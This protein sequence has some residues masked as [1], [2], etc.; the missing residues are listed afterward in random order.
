MIPTLELRSRGPVES[1]EQTNLCLEERVSRSRQA[2]YES[3]MGAPRNWTDWQKAHF[4]YVQEEVRGRS[5]L[6]AAFTPGEPSL[7]PRI[8]PNQYLYRVERIDNLLRNFATTSGVSVGVA[9]LND[10]ISARNAAGT[11]A[12]AAPTIA[13]SSPVAALHDLTDLFNDGRDGR[14][15]F[16]ACAAEFPGLDRRRDWAEHMCE[17][18]GLANYRED[19]TSEDVTL[20]LFRYR[21]QEVLDQTKH[22]G[23]RAPRFAAPTVIDQ[24]MS[25][26]YF[27]A[28]RGIGRGYAVGLSPER[29]CSHLA[30]ELIHVRIDYSADHWV[31]VDTLNRSTLSSATVASLRDSHLHCI[32]RVHRLPIYGAGCI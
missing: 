6:S 3:M 27:P 8:E 18:C 19:V 17:R 26:V 25:N 1:A 4:R 5:P 22:L 31:A 24:G 7:R 12:T 9:V 20:A 14:P 11:A 29:D 30:S 28:P 32:R 23:T 10:W 2:R 21:V 16:V 15:T 13:S